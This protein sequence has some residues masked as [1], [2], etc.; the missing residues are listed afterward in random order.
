MHFDSVSTDYPD[1]L[2]LDPP[3]TQSEGQSEDPPKTI[4]APISSEQP[5]QV[6]QRTLPSNARLTSIDDILPPA[7]R[8][9]SIVESHIASCKKE[10]KKIS[11]AFKAENLPRLQAAQVPVERFLRICKTSKA[12]EYDRTKFLSD[13][14]KEHIATLQQ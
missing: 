3:E 7:E 12:P 5:G 2:K 14:L 4:P 10:K 1:F 8:I 11:D 13:A 9:V 6:V